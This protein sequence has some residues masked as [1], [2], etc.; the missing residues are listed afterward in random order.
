MHLRQHLVMSQALIMVL[1]LLVFPLA[2]YAINELARRTDS[3]TIDNVRALEATDRMRREVGDEITALLHESLQ[4]RSLVPA[5]SI[6]AEFPA[7]AAIDAARTH[8]AT[9]DERAAFADFERDYTRLRNSIALWRAGQLAAASSELS[10]NYDATRLTG[11]R[12]HQLKLQA[13]EERTRAARTFAHSVLAL[14]IG[15]GLL[16]LLF[17]LL[18]TRRVV[19]SILMPVQRFTGLTRRIGGGDF[20]IGYQPGPIDEFNQLERHFESMSNALRVSR[21]ANLERLLAEQRRIDAV[22]ESIGDGLVIFSERGRIE[23]INGVAERQLGIDPGSAVGCTFEEIGD[24]RV[25]ARVHEILGAGDSGSVDRE[26]EVERDGETRVLAFGI[27][28]FVES[29]SNSPGVVMV[30]RDVTTQREFD[31]MRSDFVMRA[32]HELRTPI[33]SIRM[34]LSLLGEKLNFAPG[35]RDEEL[36]RTVETELARMITLLG[37]LLDLTRLRAG[38]AVI[39]RMPVYLEDVLAGARQRFAVAA[40][41]KG[42]DLGIDLERGLPRVP[43]CRSAF[44]R[45]LDN[46]ITNALR[47]TPGKGNITLSAHREEE[48]ILIAVADSSEG[49]PYAQQSLVFQPFVQI[50]NRRGGAGL[51][52]AICKEIVQQHGGEIHVSSLPRR[53]A[54]FTISLPA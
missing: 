16:A 30:M 14:L 26:L 12:L 41:Q 32:S 25:A 13:L 2:V 24:T 46:L 36:F 20:D 23:R 48:R 1:T 28:R 19:N 11:I 38:A 35:S 18:A 53:G 39:D 5:A 37:D 44:D 52:L 17:A 8:F 9:P 29:G 15:L 49:I 34:G 4:A 21:E 54:T 40:S 10:A 33:T 3:M 50:G 43:L 42:V 31:R 45:V 27:N 22:L 7:R 51:G 6:R 47:Y